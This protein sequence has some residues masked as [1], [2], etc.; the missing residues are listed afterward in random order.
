[1]TC[2]TL[3][4]RWQGK[5][6]KPLPT[7]VAVEKEFCASWTARARDRQAARASLEHLEEPPSQ[8]P[9]SIARYL[10]DDTSLLT[11]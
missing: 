11:S 6:G 2:Q 3:R 5:E 9:P 8:K 1:M 10:T 4:P 7:Q